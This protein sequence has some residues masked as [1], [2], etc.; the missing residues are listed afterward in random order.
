M[1]RLRQAAFMGRDCLLVYRADTART[2]R[3]LPGALEA[4]LLLQV[5]AAEA[6]VLIHLV[7]EVEITLVDVLLPSFRIADLAHHGL[8]HLAGEDLI[9]DG[10]DA[11]VDANLGRL[12]LAEVKIRSAEFDERAEVVVN[13]GHGGRKR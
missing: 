12:P 6:V 13:D 4:M 11:A 8:H 7:G 2:V 10:L 5:V 9:G 1:L 3:W